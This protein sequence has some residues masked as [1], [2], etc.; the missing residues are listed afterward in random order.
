MFKGVKPEVLIELS[1]E[2][3]SRRYNVGD[4]VVKE[5]TANNLMFIIESGT[6]DVVKNLGK[7][8][9]I[10]VTKLGAMQSFGEMSLIESAP[11][12]A[13]IRVSEPA[14]ILG[15]SAPALLR[16]SRKHPDAYAKIIFNLA[17]DLSKRLRQM[18]EVVGAVSG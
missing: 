2:M 17:K 15:L 12:S 4:I 3:V 8:N 10:I 18:V 5:G 16:M 7:K 11:R 14:C 9:E 6:V 1:K 13:S